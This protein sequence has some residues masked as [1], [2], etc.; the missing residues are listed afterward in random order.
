MQRATPPMITMLVDR[1]IRSQPELS[2]IRVAR[3][4][5][6]SSDFVYKRRKAVAHG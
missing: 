4:A 3:L 5:G 1:L 2:A 6:C